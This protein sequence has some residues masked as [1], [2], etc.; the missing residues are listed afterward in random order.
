MRWL[1]WFEARSRKRNAERAMLQQEAEA[2]LAE[3]GRMSAMLRLDALAAAARDA[4]ER[5]RVEAVRAIVN[6]LAPR[7]PRPDTATRMHYRD[8]GSS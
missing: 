3:G 1:A 4:T 2:L 8:G 6:A 5:R 7:P